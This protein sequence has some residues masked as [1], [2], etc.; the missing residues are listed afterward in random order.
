MSRL[1]TNVYSRQWFDLFARSISAQQTT[2]EVDFLSRQ[3]PYP[4]YNTMLDLCCGEGRHLLALA[5]RGYT[6]TG[7][8]I[9]AAALEVARE[10][11]SAHVNLVRCDMREIDTLK[12]RFD[13]LVCLWQSFGYFDDD[14][15]ATILRSAAAMLRER[16]RIVFDLYHRDFFAN[17]QG[18]RRIHSSPEVQETKWMKDHRL[19]VKLQYDGHENAEH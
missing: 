12:S 11:V 17:H 6:V 18:Q 7:A 5:D 10:R 14:K 2:R 1:S 16:G 15:N 9:N 19:H 3:L 8:D 4:E 13:A